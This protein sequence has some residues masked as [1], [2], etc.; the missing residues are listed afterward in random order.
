M[1]TLNARPKYRE[2]GAVRAAMEWWL[3]SLPI[4]GLELSPELCAENFTLFE[5]F[6]AGRLAT[7][8]RNQVGFVN[9]IMLSPHIWARALPLPEGVGWA[10]GEGISC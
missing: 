1:E 9:G 6:L 10:P 8:N 2:A 7:Y 4:S 5:V 3:Q